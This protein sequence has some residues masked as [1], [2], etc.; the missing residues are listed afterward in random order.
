LIIFRLK[1]AGIV[2]ILRMPD[3][4]FVSDRLDPDHSTI[5][6]ENHFSSMFSLSFLFSSA[7]FGKRALAQAMARELGPKARSH[8]HFLPIFIFFIF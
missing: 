3:P 2:L 5:S 6:V 1:I 4:G 7:K 8:N